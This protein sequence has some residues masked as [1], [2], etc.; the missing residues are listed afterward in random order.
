MDDKLKIIEL[1]G[2]WSVGFNDVEIVAF[3]GPDARARAERQWSELSQLL[4]QTHLAAPGRDSRDRNR[5]GI[6]PG[7]PTSKA[8]TAPR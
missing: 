3:A 4:S 1:N 5:D 8:F 7:P 6:E 2:R